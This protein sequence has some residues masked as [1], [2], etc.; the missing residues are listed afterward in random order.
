M[1][2]PNIQNTVESMLGNNMR[3]IDCETKTSV[4]QEELF[5]I[6]GKPINLDDT[7]NAALKNVFLTGEIPACSVMND[8]LIRAGI[9]ERN[10]NIETSMTVKSSIVSKEEI[11]IAEKG[12]LLKSSVNQSNE[13]NLYSSYTSEIWSNIPTT[14]LISNNRPTNTLISKTLCDSDYKT[15]TVVSSK[16]TC[17]INSCEFFNPILCTNSMI[18]LNKTLSI[19]SGNYDKTGT[20]SSSSTINECPNIVSKSN[21]NLLTVLPQHENVSRIIHNNI[22]QLIHSIFIETESFDYSQY[23]KTIM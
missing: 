21:S 14:N 12:T 6:N 5:L 13:E 10:V 8:I 11:Q 3:I 19:D 22:S 16:E 18:L 23:I 17:K 4:K 15:Q 2:N 7:E 1:D 20:S 9:L